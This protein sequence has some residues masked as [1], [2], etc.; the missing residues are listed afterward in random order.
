MLQLKFTTKCEVANFLG[1]INPCELVIIDKRTNRG[2]EHAQKL[3]KDS[4]IFYIDYLRTT[5]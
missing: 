5:D 1:Q 3:P 2:G 4:T